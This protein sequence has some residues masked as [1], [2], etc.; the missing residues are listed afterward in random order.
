[1]ENL[2]KD[3]RYALRMLRKNP[4][5]SAVAV[6]T[7]AL[8]IGANTAMF[9]VVNGVL[10][11]PLPY[12]DSREVVH[13]WG[14]LRDVPRNWLSDPEWWELTDSHPAFS[15]ISAYEPGNGANLSRPGVDPLR[16]TVASSTSSL[17]QLL[18]VQA[19]LGRTFVPDEDQPGHSQVALL[20]HKLWK[21]EFGGDP[22]IVGRKIQLDAE[23]YDVVGI[24]PESF[25]FE[26]DNDVWTPLGLNRAKQGNRG[27]H[28][29]TVLA[30]L[31]PGVSIEQGNQA[32]EQFAHQ[33]GREYPDYY[34]PDTDWGMYVTPLQVDVVG[35]IRPALWVLLGAVAFVLLIACANI[36]N[37]L[38]AR[39]SARQKEIAIRAA[40]GAGKGRLIRQLLTENLVLALLG[41]SLGLLLA[42]WGVKVIVA[43]SA[44]SLPRAEGIKV[45]GE[46]LLFTLAVSVLTGLLVGLAPAWHVAYEALSDSLKERASSQVGRQR[47][48]GVLVV[49]EVALSLILLV[50]AG[51]MIR[52][53]QRLLK[54]DPG[55]KTEHLL[56]LQTSLPPAKYSNDA[57]VTNFYRTLEERLQHLPGVKSVGAVSEL[58]LS[59]VYSSGSAVFEHTPVDLPKL[60]KLELSYYESDLRFA[61]PGYFSAMNIP[62]VK[63]RLPSD[64]DTENAPLVAFVDADFAR[65]F[66]P[67]SDPIG[68]RIAI[69]S[70]NPNPPFMPRWRTVVGIVGHVKHY[71]LEETGREQVYFP[72]AQRAFSRDLFLVVRANSDPTSLANSIR[73]QVLAMD[74]EQPIYGVSTM[75]Q[76]LETSV[77]QPRLNLVLLALFAALALVLASV[78]IYG[79]ISYSVTQRTR[80][81]GIRMALGA[82]QGTVLRMIV[83]QGLR[84]TAIGLLIGVAGALVLTRLIS[85]LLFG[86]SATDPAT[87][88]VT[89]LVLGGVALLASYLPA[90]RA[91]GVDPLV[92]LHHE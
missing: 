70:V 46:V 26:G 92:A 24:L 87:F 13:V 50:G 79:I 6:L 60:P 75:D 63:G 23:S 85:A 40:L 84:L 39:A 45:N 31:G 51:L 14:K 44:G 54:V 53:F 29:L 86:V 21:N 5:F 89:L 20:S 8:G 48:R 52:S 49:S 55:F 42:L 9:S 81:I 19:E 82:G 34:R 25:H 10:L 2:L 69:D 61:T 37:L 41:G 12:R 91:A 18:G 57:S 83:S 78:G 73:E 74:P 47:V 32:V 64:S 16:I 27:S 62:L 33:L 59:G 65:R 1:M 3:V 66:W 72:H 30:R 76:L 11:K 38:L 43:L 68:Q 28:G 17:F 88:I 15:Q 90:R 36:A 7:L 80:E 22:S 77:A 67:N 58:P 4:A 35:S 56:T 71:S